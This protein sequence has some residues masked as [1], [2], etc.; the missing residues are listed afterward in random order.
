[1]SSLPEIESEELPSSLPTTRVDR[2]LRERIRR[3]RSH[4][5]FDIAEDMPPE[6]PVLPAVSEPP[7][8]AR[9]VVVANRLPVTCSRDAQ[10]KW[11]LQASAGGLVSALKGV[12]NYATLWIGWPGIYVKPGRDRDDL[13]AIL[14]AEGFLPVWMDTTL[15]DLYYNGFCNSVL[16]QLFHY[17]PLN[18]DTWQKMAEHRAM[19]LQ[20]QAYQASQMA[21]EKFADVVLEAYEVAD[22]V[23]VQDYHLMLLPSLL[24][25]NVPKM[26]VGFFL[27][28]PFPSSEMY[29]TLPVREE[30]LRAVLA[31]DLVGFHTYDYARHFISSCTRILGLE[32]TPEGVE[33][34]GVLT[35]VGTFPIGIDP[36]RFTRA[37]ESEEVQSQTAKLL[38]RYAGR[39]IM[40]GVDRLDMVKGIPQKLLAYEKFLEEH[41]EWRDKV[42]L[43]QIA[44][45]SRT[46]VPEYQKLRSMVHEIVGRING[47]YGTLTYVPIY[48]LDTSLSFTELCALY[49]VTD[50]AMVTSLRD[51]MNLVS[52]EYVACQSDNAGVL[53]L[54][55]FAG[56]A[57]SLGAGAL[58]VNPWNIS[59]MSQAIYDALSMSEEERRERHRQ[60]YMHVQTH[61]AQHWADTFITELNDTHIEADLRMRH[62]PP[63]L[64]VQE[65]VRAYQCSKRRLVVL[66]YNATLTTSVE[67]P[68]LPKRQFEQVKALAKVNPRVMQSVCELCTDPANVVVIF[69]GSETTK[70]DEI[71]GHLPVWLAAENG[72]YVRPPAANGNAGSAGAGRQGGSGGPGCSQAQAPAEPSASPQWKCVFDQVHCEWM[73]SVQLVFDYF[74]E[75][76][77][78]SFVEARETSLVWNYKYADMEFG[79][80][81]ARDL[82]QH[83]WTGPISNAPVEIIQ[84]GKSVEVRPVGV[85]KGLAMQRLVG[86]IA[87][88]GGIE[89]AAF[90][91][92]LC[93][94]HLLGRDENLFSLFEGARIDGAAPVHNSRSERF[95]AANAAAAAAAAAGQTGQ[96]VLLPATVRTRVGAVG[97]GTLG[98]P[99]A[100]HHVRSSST[101]GLQGTVEE[102]Q[103]GRLAGSSGTAA[104]AAAGGSGS[105]SGASGGAAGSSSAAAAGWQ[106]PS[107]QQLQNPKASSGITQA[108]SRT[109]ASS[110][111]LAQSATPLPQSNSPRDQTLVPMA[112]AGSSAASLLAPQAAGAVMS[113]STA[114]APAGPPALAYTVPPTRSHGHLHAQH[115]A[116][117]AHPNRA[118]LGVVPGHHHGPGAQ[119]AVLP[120]AGILSRSASGGG[121][122]PGG[123]AAA[124]QTGAVAGVAD[125]AGGPGGGAVLP[126]AGGSMPA[127]IRKGPGTGA[128]GAASLAGSSGHSHHGHRPLQTHSMDRLDMTVRVVAAAGAAA[129]S[130]NS[131]V[132]DRLAGIFP[133]KYLYTCTVGRNRSK[134]RYALATSAEVGDLLDAIVQQGIYHRPRA[135]ACASSAPA[136]FSLGGL[137]L[138][139]ARLESVSSADALS[140]SML[141]S[142]VG[143][144]AAGMA[145]AG[146][147][148]FREGDRLAGMSL[149][150]DESCS[151]PQSPSDGC[152]TAAGPGVS[153]RGGT[154]PSNAPPHLASL[155]HLPSSQH[156]SFHHHHHG[157]HGHNHHHNHHHNH[158]QAQPQTRQAQS[159][160]QQPMAQSPLQQQQQSFG[161]S[162]LWNNFESRLSVSNVGFPGDHLGGGATDATDA[163]GSFGS[164][165]EHPFISA[166]IGPSSL[167]HQP[168]LGSQ[169]LLGAADAQ[170]LQRQSQQQT[171]G[172]QSGTMPSPFKASDALGALGPAG[173]ADEAQAA[174]QGPERGQAAGAVQEA[175]SGHVQ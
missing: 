130:G 123:S 143:A 132:A 91:M 1:M 138:Q 104:A 139:G 151:M 114:A 168:M 95:A 105:G 155:G 113:G 80:I 93:I 160:G 99:Q 30:V 75:R 102:L 137:G 106:P 10:G 71:F 21:N 131:T 98:P 33:N 79:R 42:L 41:P 134:A 52:Y 56:A 55:E 15:L 148:G 54:S 82:L 73:E 144:Q 166:S 59:D 4:Q 152:A 175:S 119:T 45:P 97:L 69:S 110:P 26:K 61:T 60:N 129:A 70:L 63:P 161:A 111:F 163:A 6:D 118:G 126:G 47:Q 44:V 53:V 13:T 76:T 158:R 173:R 67:A 89:A 107:Q 87:A 101:G 169:L 28:T 50:V 145:V 22:V 77:P 65:V 32:G 64:D 34:N 37:L 31:A 7:I 19:Q 90:D 121:A 11:H 62:T 135:A 165:S 116:H 14:E 156:Y 18:I 88:E 170:L 27:H 9:L 100:V 12:S 141:T 157:V 124:T 133:P 146:M 172:P 49:A 83:L 153:S 149:P 51:G 43:V 112:A 171:G 84:G 81:Q 74:C 127:V 57:Q 72:V 24:K 122:A 159:S 58:L 25:Q 86:L 35:R 147:R 17:V 48:H 66:G 109:Q 39:K 85:T 94:G 164:G 46:D 174:A 68:R 96:D 142:L 92:V 40:L 36:E 23:W 128:F 38:N 8:Q 115:H 117:G 125:S 154:G 167:R 5:A 103:S 3:N 20:W 162:D 108:L 150:L 16:W 29:R 136:E 120:H 78:R 2:L 140:D